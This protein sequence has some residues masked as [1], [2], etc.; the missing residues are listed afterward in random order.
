MRNAI[1]DDVFGKIA[2]VDGFD[3]ICKFIQM[4]N[5]VEVLIEST[6]NSC[7]FGEGASSRSVSSFPGNKS[8]WYQFAQEVFNVLN[9]KIALVT[10]IKAI[11]EVFHRVVRK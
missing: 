1:I 4:Y 10:L 11:K 6:N 3:A 9:G 8:I 7:R 2:M 5:L